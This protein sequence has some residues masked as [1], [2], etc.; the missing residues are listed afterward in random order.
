MEQGAL[1]LLL[2]VVTALAT[3]LGALPFAFVPQISPKVEARAHAL[4]AGLMLGACFGLAAEGSISGAWQT[5]VGAGA[6]VMFILVV[7]GLLDPLPGSFR[8][9]GGRG[10][11]RALL[12]LVVMTA[13]SAAEGVAI[14]VS[15]GGREAL[16][17]AITLAI[18]VHN[19]PEGLAIT[20]VLRPSGAS[21]ARCAGW[22]AFSSLPQPALAVPAFWFVELFRTALPYG[23][24]FA[25]G[26]MAFLVLQELL[27]EAYRRGAASGVALW[28]SISLVLM[29]LF[30]RSI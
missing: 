11:R 12:V 17:L 19:I 30:Q 9:T 28:V 13:H 10:G 24:G 7:N 8:P 4:S 23:L 29:V 27:P 25:A 26:A 14:G 3:A 5:L 6:G 21:L 22:S 1:V 15:F 2:A 16:A 18:A 20:A